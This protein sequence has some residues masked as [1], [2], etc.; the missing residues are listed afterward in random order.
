LLAGRA[1]LDRIAGLRDLLAP[2]ERLALVFFFGL[3]GM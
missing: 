3:A 2:E 1:A